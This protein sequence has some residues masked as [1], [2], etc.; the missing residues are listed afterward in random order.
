MAQLRHARPLT[1]M[2]DADVAFAATQGAQMQRQTITFAGTCSTCQENY[3]AGQTHCA[4]GHPT[5][6]ASFEDRA[7]YEVAAWR[8]HQERSAAAV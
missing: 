3:G 8:R 2:E 6:Y 4:S 7:A 1:A 5:P